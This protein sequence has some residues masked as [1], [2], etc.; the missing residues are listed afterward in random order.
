[1]KN[2][3]IVGLG[4]AIGSSARYLVQRYVNE[5]FTG[6]FPIST[7]MINVVG[8]F[9]IGL[10]YSAGVKQNLVPEAAGLFLITGIC[11]GFTTFSAFGLENM[12]LIKGGYIGS[13]ILYSCGSV[14]AG[15]IAVYLGTLF[16]R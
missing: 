1:M 7:F 11:G 10:I 6:I 4:G 16:F 15:I 14:I 12:L 9:F 13:V 5:S 3:L 8:C 2:I